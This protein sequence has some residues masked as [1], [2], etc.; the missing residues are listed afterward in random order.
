MNIP[1]KEI[2][3]M[4][5][6]FRCLNWWKISYKRASKEGRASI[7][8]PL[9]GRAILYGYGRKRIPKDFYLHEILHCAIRDLL[10]LDKRYRKQMFKAE[11]QLVQDICKV[12]VGR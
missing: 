5:K 6:H 11:E 9:A 10:S 4:K 7:C 1:S 12:K 3:R 2:S 8:S